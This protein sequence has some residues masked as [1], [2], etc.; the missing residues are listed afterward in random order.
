MALKQHTIT[1]NKSAQ[2][3]EHNPDANYSDGEKI[4]L[5]EKVNPVVNQTKTFYGFD[6]IDIFT[7]TTAITA[8]RVLIH[9]A[10]IKQ[11][12]PSGLDSSSIDVTF[13]LSVLY[14][15]WNECD[16]TYNNA[17]NRGL[18]STNHTITFQSTGGTGWIS[19]DIDPA[20]YKRLGK[21][22]NNGLNITATSTYSE[23]I[24]YS[25]RA[26]EILR[27]YLEIWTEDVVPI[28]QPIN[29]KGIINASSDIRFEWTYNNDSIV[30]ADQK[31][32]E[33]QVSENGDDWTPIINGTGSKTYHDY[34]GP[35]ELNADVKYWRV[36]ATSAGDVVGQWSAA[37]EI[38]VIMPPTVYITDIETAP[39][40]TITWAETGQRGYQ[41]KIGNY[42]SGPLYGSQ[43]SF[44]SPV[45]IPDGMTQ[46]GLRVVGEYGL[47]SDWVY[48]EIE[49][50]NIPNEE[51]IK[52]NATATHRAT[53]EWD[54]NDEAEYTV[55]RDGKEIDTINKTTYIDELVIGRHTYQVRRNEGDYYT[56]S[57]LAE[58]EMKCRYPMITS[59]NNVDW[60][61]IKDTLTATPGV[62]V[63]RSLEVNYAYY[64]G[65][66]RPAAETNGFVNDTL[67]F[68]AAFRNSN[69]AKALYALGGSEVCYKD[70]RNNII[71]GILENLSGSIGRM[72]SELS[73]TIV[74]TEEQ[75]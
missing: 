41:V 29:P 2:V 15:G 7:N 10:E 18:V 25:T 4:V 1:F 9:I 38:T 60:L 8:A 62:R 56:L 23:I 5:V 36:R 59:V 17:P 42:D 54:G 68:S 13:A 58:L 53:L 12:V 31:T 35:G 22:L 61:E 28:T 64:A 50:K 51:P 45:Y 70:P 6:E 19:L 55:I 49:I 57:N 47:W 16:I 69:T 37:Q 40:P 66:K 34:K 11:E 63:S 48:E 46:I 52:L 75:A 67:D 71:I 44:K 65:R 24:A 33:I 72:Y 74:A 26:E 20:Y 39:K 30:N 32:Y 73:G 21:Y 43:S 3:S 27:P 14:A